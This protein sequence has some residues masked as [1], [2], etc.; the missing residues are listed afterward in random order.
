MQKK[1]Y[2]NKEIDVTKLEKLCKL[3]IKLELKD[4]IKVKNKLSE[5]DKDVSIAIK[6]LLKIDNV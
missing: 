4:Y 6:K 3:T 5:I 2:E 1:I